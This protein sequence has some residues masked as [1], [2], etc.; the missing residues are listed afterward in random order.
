MIDAAE[1]SAKAREFEIN[2]SNV[3]RDYI[4]GWMLSG[5][6]T[7]SALKDKLF[8]KGGN[9][10]RKGYF[11]NTRYSTDLD[12]GIPDDISEEDL[13]SE[14]NK[15]CDFIHEKNGVL[16]VN[17][18]NKVEEKFTASEAPIPGLKVYEA[19]VYFKDFFGTSDHIIIRISMDITR[20]DKVM[21]PLQERQLIHPYSDA[22]EVVCTIRCMKL[23]EIIA[24]K[25]KCLLQRQHA[26]DLFDYVYS[27]RLL[28]G[29]IDKEEI[30]RVFLQKT[31]FSSN[32]RVLKDI[33]HN[34][35]FDYFRSYWDKTLIC[36][37]QVF[38]SVEEAIEFFLADLDSLFS[39]YGDS[40]YRDFAFFGADLRVPIMK[41]GREQTMLRVVYKGEE[42]MIEPY[43]LKYMEKKTGEAPLDFF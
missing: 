30:V 6:F 19:R 42:R 14:I 25:L 10:L 35:A 2:E 15:V 36:A 22:A 26:P 24:T 5:F 8:L 11:E 27:I 3:Q 32:P 31:I 20:F 7:V 17:E 12:F 1:I 21:L 40:G 37:K 43:S 39:P 41:A 4:F 9:A 23:E 16:F 34:T 13:L 38:F 29:D 28:G 18:K 33:L